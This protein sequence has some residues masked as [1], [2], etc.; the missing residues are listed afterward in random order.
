MTFAAAGSAVLV[1][2]VTPAFAGEPHAADTCQPEIPGEL[3]RDEAGCPTA[4]DPY[5]KLV[6]D[7]DDHRAWYGRFW[8]GTCD[9]LSFWQSIRCQSGE[10]DWSQLV[11]RTLAR[12]PAARR[13]YLKFYLWRLGRLIGFE[14]ARDNDVRK[15]DTGTL[16][17]WFDWLDHDG[18][19]MHALTRV[20]NAAHEALKRAD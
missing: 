16:Q 2:L 12:A 10:P 8:T 9:G 5:A 17:I 7:S 20:S 13:P 11:D 15:I 19:V 3:K 18:D 4:I 6:F 14:W 1:A